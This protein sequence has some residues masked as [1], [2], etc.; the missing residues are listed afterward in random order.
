MISGGRATGLADGVRAAL[1]VVAHPDDESFGLGAVLG[2]LVASGARCAVLCFTRGEASTL[3]AGPGELARVRPA[4]FAA[5]A[6]ALGITDARLLGYPDGA[7]SAIP[8]AELAGRV[9]A[10]ARD[11]GASHLLA[12]D[13]GGVTGHPDHTRATEAALAAGAALGI[14][15]LGWALP[16]AVAEALNAEFGTGFSG[17]Q[18]G[19]LDEVLTVDRAPQWRA[20]GCHRS[21][22]A[23]NP[24]LWRRLELLGDAE[25]VRLLCP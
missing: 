9:Q 17:R 1:A 7:L 4:E 12:F 23:D 15:V 21:Q 6:R 20:I 24:V 16:Q 25:H 10:A 13:T 19:D 18:A 8:L 2:E 5:A 11:A 3:H 14:P 22:S